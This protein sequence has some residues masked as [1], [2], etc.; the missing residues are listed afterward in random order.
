MGNLFARETFLPSLIRRATQ[1]PNRATQ[2][3]HDI[4]STTINVTER[5]T[6][7]ICCAALWAL[8]TRLKK[9]A[10][11]MKGSDCGAK[12]RE[13]VYKVSR[14]GAKAQAPEGELQQLSAKHL[15]YCQKILAV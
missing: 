9:N 6:T 8:A 5:K 10:S 2:P 11:L 15:V 1:L 14:D 12:L 13:V 3:A 7:L 4:S